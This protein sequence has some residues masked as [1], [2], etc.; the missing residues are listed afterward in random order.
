MTNALVKRMHWLLQG[1]E[2]GAARAPVVTWEAFA[3]VGAESA[4]RKRS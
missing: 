4:R 1:M 3:D 2:E